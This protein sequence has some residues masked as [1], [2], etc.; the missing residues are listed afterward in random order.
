M[1]TPKD[2][3]KEKVRRLPETPGVYL[4]KDGLGRILYVGKAKNLKRRVSS[5]FQPSR[6]QLNQ[7]P[8]V[9][10]MIELIRD[11]DTIAVRSDA[12][13]LLLESKLIKEHRPKHNTM[14]T[15]DKRFLMI[16]VDL[17][18]PIPIFQLVRTRKDNKSSYYVPF[19]TPN[20]SAP[21]TGNCKINSVSSS[22][23]P[24]PPRP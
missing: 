18:N 1:K 16:R 23:T 11:F 24:P 5:Y 10:A 20:L 2:E 21:P 6:K 17:H 8:K 15:D 14:L 19:P 12:E 9:N 22:T 3:L 7:Q 4:M 13:A